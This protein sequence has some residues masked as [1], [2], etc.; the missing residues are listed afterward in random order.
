MTIA[1][2]LKE[3]E[4]KLQY[5][6]KYSFVQVP[7]PI[8]YGVLSEFKEAVEVL[9]AIGFDETKFNLDSLSHDDLKQCYK[10]DRSIVKDLLM[11]WGVE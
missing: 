11:K 8:A 4:E 5:Y 3:W 2:L 9:K 6:E 1:E 7:Y 10:A